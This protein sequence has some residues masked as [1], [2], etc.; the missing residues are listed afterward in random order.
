MALD[1]LVA[2]QL[3]VVTKFTAL[4]VAGTTLRG[5]PASYVPTQTEMDN[6]TT[7]YLNDVLQRL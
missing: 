4:N 1:D 5:F 7:T 6:W 3:F 2:K